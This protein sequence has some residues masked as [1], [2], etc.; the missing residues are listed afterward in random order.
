M[1][2]LVSKF[3]IERRNGRHVITM[4][5]QSSSVTESVFVVEGDSLSDNV[6]QILSYV[7][8]ECREFYEGYAPVR[9][10]NLWG[11]VDV[12][13]CERITPAYED[14]YQVQEGFALVKK[15]DKYT[16]LT[17]GGVKWNENPYDDASPFQN[18]MAVVKRDGKY[19]YISR[20]LWDAEKI[21]CQYEKA[22]GFNLVYPYAV[23]M[24]DGKYGM[25][26]KS[27]NEVVKLMFDSYTTYMRQSG[28]LR[29]NAT[30]GDKLYRLMTDGTY[31]EVLSQ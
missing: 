15:E 26:D 14:V 17:M 28:S 21:P 11:Y 16:F 8:D 30:I 18:G 9:C 23:V 1:G 31:K 25:I 19:G 10:G 2:K 7:Y 20:E 5:D 22:F 27:G 4:L 12:A 13:L 29:Y 24:K 6:K 3:K